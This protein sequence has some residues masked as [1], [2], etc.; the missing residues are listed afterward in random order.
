MEAEFLKKVGT[1]PSHILFI[2]WCYHYLGHLNGRRLIND[3][4][5]GILKEVGL[6]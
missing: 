6:T 4:L 5:E 2:L 1:F 3:E